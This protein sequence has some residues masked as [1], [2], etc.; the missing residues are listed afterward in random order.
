MVVQADLNSVRRTQWQRTVDE[1]SHRNFASAVRKTGHMYM[2]RPQGPQR[3][4]TQESVPGVGL[5][6]AAGFSGI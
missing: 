3:K 6:R 4:V 2:H 5:A 1:N